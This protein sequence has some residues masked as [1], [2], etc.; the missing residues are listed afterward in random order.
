MWVVFEKR[1]EKVVFEVIRGAERDERIL[2]KLFGKYGREIV[3]EVPLGVPV[4]I[5]VYKLKKILEGKKKRT[6]A[7][8][9]VQK[10]TPVMEENAVLTSS[11][12]GTLA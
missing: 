3:K 10:R 1:G 6:K 7:R 4:N 2:T 9:T 12:E 5:D 8:T 11:I